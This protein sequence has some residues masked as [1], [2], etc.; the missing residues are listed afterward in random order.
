MAIDS[1]S[2]DA[3]APGACC[4]DGPAMTDPP[5]TSPE[6]IEG[7]C[8]AVGL[9]ARIA[10]ASPVPLTW[11]VAVPPPYRRALVSASRAIR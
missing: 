9:V 5:T 11:R 10:T 6:P 1:I 3:A 7:R 2:F 8:G 4:R